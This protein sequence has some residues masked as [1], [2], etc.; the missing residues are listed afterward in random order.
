M[1]PDSNIAKTMQCAATKTTMV[2]KCLGNSQLQS[3]LERMKVSP[4]TLMID[5]SN[6]RGSDKVSTV[7][8]QITYMRLSD[9]CISI[10]AIISFYFIF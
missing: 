5:E 7:M 4:F 8:Q 3:A 10:T 6:D 9:I 1:F 2:A